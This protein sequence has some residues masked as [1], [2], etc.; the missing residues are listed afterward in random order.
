MGDRIHMPVVKIGFARRDGR[1]DFSDEEV[2][3][4]SLGPALAQGALAQGALPA[5]S[6]AE[7]HVIDVDAFLYFYPLIN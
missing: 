4:S 6:E 5:I 1:K 3:G 2:L 7:A